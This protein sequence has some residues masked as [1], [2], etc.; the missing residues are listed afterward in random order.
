[1]SMEISSVVGRMVG[2]QRGAAGMP[3]NEGANTATQ[4]RSEAPVR[5]ELQ[6]DDVVRDISMVSQT[7]NRRL[8]FHVNEELGQVIVKVIDSETD[9]VIKELP[10]Q[11]LQRLHVR[12]REMIGLL[13]DEEI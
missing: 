9:K 11:A 7:F 4:V 12:I 10:P 1:M 8:K 6:L 3:Q 13:I 2:S 5:A